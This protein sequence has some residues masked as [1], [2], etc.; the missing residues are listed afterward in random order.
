M[1]NT[2]THETTHVQTNQDLVQ[3]HVRSVVSIIDLEIQNSV[4]MYN[5][6]FK[7]K[8]LKRKDEPI[9]NIHFNYNDAR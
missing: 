8:K 9:E 7:A 2:I 4:S 1:I 3:G 5:I 6:I